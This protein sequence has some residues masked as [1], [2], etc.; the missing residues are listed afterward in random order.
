MTRSAGGLRPPVLLAAFLTCSMAAAPPAEASLLDRL[1]N[2]RDA[3]GC[4][5]KAVANPLR[6]FKSGMRKFGEQT[7]TS[8]EY[9]R[10]ANKAIGE[11]REEC[12]KA[13]KDI[14]ERGFGVEEIAGRARNNA[15]KVKNAVDEVL[16]WFGKDRSAPDDRRRAL[17][18]N[19]QERRF[20]KETGVLDD[21]PLPPAA[22]VGS[23]RGHRT[24]ANAYD[25]DAGS[26][27]A[28]PASSG[29]KNTGVQIDGFVFKC[30]I[31]LA[32]IVMPENGVFGSSYYSDVREQRRDCLDD[33]NLSISRCRG[34]TF[35]LS[36]P[37]V[38]DYDLDQCRSAFERQ[39][40][41]CVVHFFRERFKC[42]AGGLDAQREAELKRIRSDEREAERLRAREEFRLH[43]ERLQTIRDRGRRDAAW[44]AER[45]D[46]IRDRER[47]TAVWDDEQRETIRDREH[48]DLAWD[49]ELRERKR[50]REDRERFELWRQRQKQQYE[51][52]ENEIEK[53]CTGRCCPRP[54]GGPESGTGSVC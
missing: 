26:R 17:S 23:K 48:A 4:S 19:D 38:A 32:G 30:R 20:Y 51:Q 1:K 50:R 22:V 8:E 18:R 36:E 47:D 12:L 37:N 34:T 3:V 16:K 52:Y 42:N 31:H 29:D 24:L 2:A 27:E 5:L 28:A 43:A 46:A 44:H 9:E 7:Y 21:R 25:A 13:A 11:A 6:V 41:E 49:A 53:P 35:R 45:Q 14:V 15:E 39:R 33:I 54:G 10:E 40:K